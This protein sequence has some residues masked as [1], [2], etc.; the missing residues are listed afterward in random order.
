MTGV[1]ERKDEAQIIASILAGNT[2]E[3]HDLIRP[4]E[5]SVYVMALSLLHNEAD[6]ED[7]AQEAFLKAFRNLAHF[8]GEAKFST[9]LISITLNEARSRLRSGKT[10]K[11]ESLDEP[12]EGQGH[13]TP[14]LLRDWR[15]I[16]SE[17]LERQE[18]RSLLQQAVTDL[19]L[20]YREVFLLRDVEEMSVNESADA[21]GITVA[22]VKVRLHRARIML[23]KMLVPQLKRVNPKRR[24][25]LWS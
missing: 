22:S 12:P 4:Y 3:F 25:S 7:A 21:L 8:R 11:M 14:A 24:W 1:S 2:H 23:Q 5:R 13:V 16:P 17:A 19:P 18:V 20:I 10:M 9:W 6:A 15:E